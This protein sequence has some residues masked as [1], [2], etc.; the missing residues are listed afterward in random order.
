MRIAIVITTYQRADGR[1]PELLTRALKSVKKQ[2]FKD[3]KIYVIGDDYKNVKELLKIT[4]HFKVNYFNLSKSEERE[5]YAFGDYKLFCTGGLT[6]SLHGVNLALNDGFDFVCHLDHDDWWNP[7][8]LGKINT[9]ISRSDCLFACTMS[10][11]IINHLPYFQETDEIA[12]YLPVP[13]QVVVSSCCI[14][15]S[16]VKTRARDVFKETGEAY[17]SDADLWQRLSVE[18]QEL[19]KNGYLYTGITCHHDEEG[20]SLK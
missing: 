13:C 8:H 7:D 6:P 19:G 1:T 9:M 16:E 4:Q 10:T 12:Y 14:K 18:I 5:L 15:Y 11:H 17:P 3:Y 20:Y 2:S